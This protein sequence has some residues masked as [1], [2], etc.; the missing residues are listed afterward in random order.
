MGQLN[1]NNEMQVQ[2][3]L[4][5]AIA[6]V[7]LDKVHEGLMVGRNIAPDAMQVRAQDTPPTYCGS[8][9]LLLLRAHVTCPAL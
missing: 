8:K 9:T 3:C 2:G 6:M 1:P 7:H 5:V 4:R